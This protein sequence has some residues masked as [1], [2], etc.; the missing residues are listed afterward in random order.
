MSKGA[1]NWTVL[2]LKEVADQF[3]V[4]MRDKP[5]KFLGKIPW[6]RIEDFDGKYIKR[7]KKGHCVDESTIENMKLKIYPTGTVLCSCSATLGICAIVQDPLISNQTFIGIV[8]NENRITSEFLFYLLKSKADELQKIST[9]TTIA[10]LPREKFESFE[11]H[12]PPLPEQKKIAEILSGF[13]H[14]ISAIS[15]KQ[16]KINLVLSQ[17]LMESTTPKASSA[18]RET[19]IGKI[20]DFQGGSQPPRS[21]FK[22]EPEEGYIRMLQIRDYKSDSRATY[23]PLDLCKRFCDKED[24]MIGRYGPPNFQILRGKEG[25]YN[26]AL[27]KAIP[28]N[29]NELK[30]EYLFRFL[31]RQDLFLLMDTLSQRT[32]GQ[33][34]LDMDALKEFPISLPDPSMQEHICKSLA[35]IESILL[36]LQYCEQSLVNLKRAI[37]DQLLSGRKRVN[38]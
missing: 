30:K 10:Y 18:W 27:I 36:G 3:I 15:K 37:A 33:Q 5:K 7:S 19:T 26:V 25:S 22:F 11:A 12:I 4:P 16:K 1:N 38:V 34:G 21:T 6:I 17:L 31:Q 13:D 23:I 35:A 29:E 28:K 2:P 8:P 14:A 9:G 24:V 20:V 32:S